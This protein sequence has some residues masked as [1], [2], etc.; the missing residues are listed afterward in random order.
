MTAATLDTQTL[1][2]GDVFKIDEEANGVFI[3][4]SQHGDH[5]VF[6]YDAT[7][8]QGNCIVEA[9]LKKST[10]SF[11]GNKVFTNGENVRARYYYPNVPSGKTD[12]RYNDYLH[13]LNWAGLKN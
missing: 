4:E 12:T 3:G 8:R 13:L 10:T 9:E 6:V 7:S 11:D 5:Y 1:T 2:L